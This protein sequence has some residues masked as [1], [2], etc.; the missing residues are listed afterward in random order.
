MRKYL[1]LAV[2]CALP[3]CSSASKPEAATAAVATLPAVRAA[4]VAGNYGEAA[5]SAQSYVAAHPKDPDG[6]FEDARAEALAGNQGRAFDALTKAVDNGLANAALALNDPAFDT[7]RSDDQF[8]ALAQR[9]TPAPRDAGA[10]SAGSGADHVNISQHGG[11][12]QIQAG[13]VKL[14]TN[15]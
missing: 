3:S 8:A 4:I 14:N 7:I 15:F 13:D 10:L 1:V 11:G 2:L 5:Q 6:Y 12:T 9:A